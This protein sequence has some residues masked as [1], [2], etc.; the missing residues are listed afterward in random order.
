M[1]G[2]GNQAPFAPVPIDEAVAAI[3]A[4][5]PDLLFAPH[6]E[7]AS[8][9]MLPDDYIKA[10]CQAAHDVGALFVLDCVASGT[11]W[12]DMKACGVDVLISAPQKGWSSSPSAGLVMLSARAL[13]VM[14]TTKS[15]SFAVDLADNEPHPD[16]PQGFPAPSRDIRQLQGTTSGVTRSA[17]DPG[18]T[19]N[20]ENF[21]DGRGL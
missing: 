4:E 12:V 21:R 5:K 13:D 18:G 7:T 6:V 11:V 8:G 9:I 15:T 19:G 1:P 3:K 20:L 17:N 16:M 14:E 10:I 2:E